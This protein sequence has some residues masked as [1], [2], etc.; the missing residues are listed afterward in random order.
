MRIQRAV[1][2]YPTI[3]ITTIWAC[4]YLSKT[5]I[6]WHAGHKHYTI[7]SSVIIVFT[8]TIWRYLNFYVFPNNSSTAT[9][10]IPSRMK[11]YFYIFPFL[12]I[13]YLKNK[14]VLLIVI[15]VKIV[16]LNSKINFLTVINILTVK[17][18]LIS[19]TILSINVMILSCINIREWV[20]WRIFRN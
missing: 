7:R 11:S 15:W 17:V 20:I 4:I 18:L 13:R 8:T 9:W 3:C 1:L 14:I 2:E 16:L 19:G 6:V 12:H 10:E 5:I